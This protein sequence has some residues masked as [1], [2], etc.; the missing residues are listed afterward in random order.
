MSVPKIQQSFCSTKVSTVIKDAVQSL[1]YKEIRK[2]QF[3]NFLNTWCDHE[4][5][6]GIM[7]DAER[8]LKDYIIT[9][10]AQ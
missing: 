3:R 7:C 6:T 1:G 8:A 2:D 9:E 5:R 4:K 10:H